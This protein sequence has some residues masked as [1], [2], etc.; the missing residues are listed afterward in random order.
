MSEHLRKHF[1]QPIAN[2]SITDASPGYFSL[3][4]ENDI[5]M[6]VTSTRRAGIERFTFPAAVKPYFV[7]DLSNDLPMSWGG[8]E[9]NIFPNNGTIQFGGRWKPRYILVPAK[10]FIVGQH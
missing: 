3:T 2:R 1:N 9:M 6:E 8:G 7:M 5:K 10:I 4:M